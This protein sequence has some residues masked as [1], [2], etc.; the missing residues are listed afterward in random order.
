VTKTDFKNSLSWVLIGLS[1]ALMVYNTVLNTIGRTV[2]D[3]PKQPEITEGTDLSGVSLR[4]PNGE[5]FAI[6]QSGNYLVS[7]L[8]TGCGPCVEQVR[9]L[10]TAVQ[11]NRY[12]KVVAIF[13]ENAREVAA[14]ESSVAPEFTC[15]V[16][17]EGLFRERFGL[18]TFPQTF[19]VNQ[20]IV[21]RGWL[22]LQK[23]FE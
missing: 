6:S 4:R 22:G 5:L 10:N 15:V 11:R 2:P 23:S 12:D 3:R 21:T 19:E 16:D 17:R 14:F 7:F 20:G 18:T 8:T 13:S 1:V 9:P